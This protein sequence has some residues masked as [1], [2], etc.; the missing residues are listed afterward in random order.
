M[1]EKNLVKENSKKKI[2][3]NFTKNIQTEKNKQ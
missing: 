3:E 2:K 1:S